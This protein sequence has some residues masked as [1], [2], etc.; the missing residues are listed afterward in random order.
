VGTKLLWT[1]AGLGDPGDLAQ[2]LLAMNA[3]DL[4]CVGATP[5]LFLDYIAVGS[6]ELMRE[7]GS[8][9]AFI[10]GLVAACRASG[11][12]LVGGETAQMPD[13]YGSKG[14]DLAGFSV[15][16]LKP[17]EHLSVE[18][19]QPGS[20]AWFWPSSGP[21]SSGFS[22]LRRIFHPEKDGRFIREHLMR[23]TELYVNPLRELKMALAGNGAADGLEAAF[24]IT[25]SGLL[26]LLRSQP[27]E[28]TIGFKL[29]A[30]D[31]SK[32]P[33]WAREVA[34][35]SQASKRDL[36]TTFNMGIGFVVV[37]GRE[38]GEKLRDLLSSLGLTRL[39]TVI[40]EAVVRVEDQKLE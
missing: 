13:V 21:H 7:G 20:E 1:Q 26:N 9:N 10:E 33:E 39:G 4:L 22:W 28:R 38:V 3:N 2:D 31:E 29:D 34:T 23:A 17:H 40:T 12:L 6:K 5:R 36:Y 16:F 19:V 30:W 37:L 8:L 15:G 27:R 35:R 11:Q 24:H 14:F 18:K 25:G 32:W